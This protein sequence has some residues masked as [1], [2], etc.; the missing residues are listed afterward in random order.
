M[1]ALISQ[2][3]DTRFLSPKLAIRH[4]TFSVDIYKEV[5]WAIRDTTTVSDALGRFFAEICRTFSGSVAKPVTFASCADIMVIASGKMA[6]KAYI[7]YIFRTSYTNII[8]RVFTSGYGTSLNY[9]WDI[10]FGAKRLIT[11][12]S[13]PIGCSITIGIGTLVLGVHF[14]FSNSNIGNGFKSNSIIIFNFSHNIQ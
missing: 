4:R 8:I 1:F 13:N 12:G 10:M 2:T 7:Y 14:D 11:A 9:L 3:C 6:I 5:G